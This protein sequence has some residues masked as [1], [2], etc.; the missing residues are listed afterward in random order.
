MD[1]VS[2]QDVFL[3]PEEKE[4]VIQL[5]NHE[6]I[7]LP[8]STIPVQPSSEPVYGGVR[9]WLRQFCCG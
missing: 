3:S 1:V 9:N 8:K 5:L 6:R 2:S 4:L 7:N